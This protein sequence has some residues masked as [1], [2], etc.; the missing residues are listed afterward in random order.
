MVKDLFDA[1]ATGPNLLSDDKWQPWEQ[2]FERQGGVFVCDNGNDNTVHRG[3]GQTVELNQD[4]PRPI[5]AV[6]WSKAEGISGGRDNNYSLY[7]DLLYADGTPLWGQT[8]PFSVGTHDWER[9]QVVIFPSKPVKQVSFYMLLRR[10]T[11]KASF[12]DPV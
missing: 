9:R 11:G 2:G 10:H 7:L 5:I 4:V 12:R 6:A 1:Q 3:V 8:A